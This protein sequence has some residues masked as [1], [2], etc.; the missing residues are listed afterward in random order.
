MLGGVVMARPLPC[1]YHVT[2]CKHPPII[3]PSIV[4]HHLSLI[5]TYTLTPPVNRTYMVLD[6]VP[7]ESPRGDTRRHRAM[8]ECHRKNWCREQTQNPLTTGLDYKYAFA[9]YFP[10]IKLE[11]QLHKQI[12]LPLVKL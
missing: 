2:P 4:Q 9:F 10:E 11:E 6:S 3:H 8:C 1:F 12:P 7:T 5:I